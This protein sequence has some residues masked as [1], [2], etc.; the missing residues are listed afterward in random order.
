MYPIYIPP[1]EGMGGGIYSFGDYFLEKYA[2]EYGKDIKGYLPGIECADPLSWPR[3]LESL[4][5]VLNGG[6]LCDDQV[7]QLHLLLPFKPR[8]Y[9]DATGICHW[10]MQWQD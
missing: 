4:K 2:K 6:S 8:R 7:I 5:T 9:R 10:R 3:M 1:F